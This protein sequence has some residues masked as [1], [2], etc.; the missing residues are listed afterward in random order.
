MN[1]KTTNS[2]VLRNEVVVDFKLQ[3]LTQ[4]EIN[5]VAIVGGSIMDHE[6]T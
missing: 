1:P 2:N 3:C 6:V 4:G 5:R